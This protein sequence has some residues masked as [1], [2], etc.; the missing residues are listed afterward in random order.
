MK[1][2]KKIMINMAMVLDLKL[3]MKFIHNMIFIVSPR[4]SSKI[5]SHLYLAYSLD[6]F[7]SSQFNKFSNSPV[8]LFK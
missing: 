1:E 6:I 4:D 7:F 2:R 3:L 8:A 5:Q